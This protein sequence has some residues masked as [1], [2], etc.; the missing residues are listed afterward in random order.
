MANR[1]FIALLIHPLYMKNA[2]GNAK[3]IPKK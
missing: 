1:G 2:A 3:T